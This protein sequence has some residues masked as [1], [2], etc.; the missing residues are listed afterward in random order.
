M[1]IKP[2]GDVSQCFSSVDAVRQCQRFS[3]LIANWVSIQR[4]FTTGGPRGGGVGVTC[5]SRGVSAGLMQEP[6]RAPKPVRLMRPTVIRII[7]ATET[8]GHG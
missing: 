7:M 8:R 4:E 6:G 2:A 3:S 1:L 5:G